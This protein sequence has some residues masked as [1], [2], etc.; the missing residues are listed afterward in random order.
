MAMNVAT[1]ENMSAIAPAPRARL[2]GFFRV[3]SIASA[4]G[5]RELDILPENGSRGAL[6]KP[7]VVFSLFNIIRHAHNY[8]VPGE[9]R[10]ILRI[11]YLPIVY[12]VFSFLSFRW[13][14]SYTYLSLVEAIYEA[15][16]LGSFLLLLVHYVAATTAGGKAEE[17]LANM[18][19]IRMPILKMSK[20]RG[21]P[22]NPAFLYKIKWAVLQ[23]SVVKPIIAIVT[24]VT[25]AAG[26]LCQGTWNFHFASP[27][28]RLVD[29]ASMTCALYGLI[30]FYLITKTLLAHRRPLPK[31]IAVKIIVFL[32]VVQNFIVSDQLSTANSFKTLRALT[33]SQL[34]ILYKHNAIHGTKMIPDSNIVNGIN[35][36]CTCIEMV[37]ISASEYKNPSLGEKRN[38]LK[39]Y[40]DS[41]NITDFLKELFAS[42]SYFLSGS[43]NN[44]RTWTQDEYQARPHFD[45]A[46]FPN[47]G[48][49]MAHPPQ[50]HHHG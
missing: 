2:E 7:T 13:F 15:F 6:T 42:F 41:I 36:I 46:F 49:N 14:S 10:Q 47:Q 22:S 20:H 35:T 48:Y 31:F 4:I 24:A 16:V 8:R 44:R 30:T 34:S 3:F 38:F 26:V 43:S 45:R 19:K 23:Y 40:W 21:D 50:G 28:L 25:Q 33:T 39:A 32:G 1:V 11:L 9:Q 18:P 27:Y 37:L 29:L 12:A 17:A 5:V